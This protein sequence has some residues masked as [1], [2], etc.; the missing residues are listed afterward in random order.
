MAFGESIYCRAIH[1]AYDVNDGDILSMSIFDFH[2]IKK[3]IEFMHEDL[4]HLWPTLSC[5]VRRATYRRTHVVCG[6][7]SRSACEMY[8]MKC[9]KQIN[10]ILIRY[11]MAIYGM[12]GVYGYRQTRPNHGG[13]SSHGNIAYTHM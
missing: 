12:L 6:V 13:S 7:V 1:I 10:M 9:H 2:A 3:F 11:G 5:R 8:Q 4:V